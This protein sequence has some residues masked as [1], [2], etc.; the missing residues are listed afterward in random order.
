MIEK[1]MNTQF[2]LYTRS[3]SQVNGRIQTTYTLN[4]NTFLC[5]IFSTNTQKTVRFGKQDY[6]V[7]RNL[8]CSTSVPL[9]LGDYVTINGVEY[10]VV[11]IVNTNNLSHHLKVALTS[12]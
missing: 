8:Y 12:R 7:S 9:V 5:A 1:F 10:D 2:R 11:D 3:Q 6:I 4:A